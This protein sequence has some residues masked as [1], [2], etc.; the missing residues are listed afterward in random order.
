MTFQDSMHRDE[1]I[2]PALLV[3]DYLR[4]SSFPW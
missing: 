2:S 1:F 4:F 3:A